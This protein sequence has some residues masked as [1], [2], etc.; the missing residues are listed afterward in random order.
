MQQSWPSYNTSDPVIEQGFVCL[1]RAPHFDEI[2]VEVVDFEK[3]DE[4][5]GYTVIRVSSLIDQPGME[6]TLQPWILRGARVRDCDM[7]LLLMNDSLLFR[8]MRRL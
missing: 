7:F 5:L 8:V 6:W 4:V 3:K 1:V 2:R